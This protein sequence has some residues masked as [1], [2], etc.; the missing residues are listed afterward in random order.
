MRT[1][2]VFLIFAAVVVRAIVVT[3][4]WPS[5]W[6]LMGLL[7][8]YGCLLL[9]AT[10][11][12]RRSG[13]GWERSPRSQTEKAGGSRIR[14]LQFAYL[15]LQSVI[16]LWLLVISTYDDFFAL[17]FIPL[18]LDA[19]AFFGR[20]W[21][22]ISIA[23]MA[24]AMLGAFQYSD[25]GRLF[26]LAMAVLYSGI[27]LLFGGYAFQVQ[28]AEAARD[29]NQRS[30]DQLRTAHRQLQGYADQVTSLAVEHERNRLA[31]DLHDSVTQTVFS[32]NL[33][34]QSTRL[35]LERDPPRAVGQLLR[36]ED[37][38]ANA[39]AE[40]QSLVLAFLS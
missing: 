6:P 39:L 10:W 34:A 2:G 33:I 24:L 7:A 15:L 28:K 14:L 3:A 37:L 18:S 16:V 1:A 17:L 4:V 19:V 30:F 13:Y 8:T 40:I 5:F 23:A 31:R 9:A 26:G 11:L 29:Q 38:A 25:E 36:I 12:T 20:R 21:G 32:M 35:L 27:C 22:F